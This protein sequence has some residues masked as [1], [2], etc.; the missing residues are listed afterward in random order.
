MT[1]DL[2]C[3]QSDL[4]VA[5]LAELMIGRRLGCLPVIDDDRR[6][7]GIVTK[8]DLVEQIEAGRATRTIADVMM[9]F[10]FTLPEHA[11]IAHAAAM[12]DCEDTH[13]VMV[14]DGNGML[15]GVVSSKDIARWVARSV[16]RVATAPR[17]RASPRRR[18]DSKR[19][20]SCRT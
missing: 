2:V 3:A 8:L 1:S 6:P 14:V 10:A 19:A 16:L 17:Q 9:P 15:V 18:S 12:M 4:D 20:G 11:T 13:H 7:I 5:Y